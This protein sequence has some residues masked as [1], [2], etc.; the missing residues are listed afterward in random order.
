[1]SARVLVSVSPFGDPF[2]FDAATH[3]SVLDAR[4]VFD[5][6][7]DFDALVDSDARFVSDVLAD[8]DA[9]FVLDVFFVSDVLGVSGVLFVLGV[10]VASVAVWPAGVVVVSVLC[11]AVHAPSLDSIDCLNPFLGGCFDYVVAPVFVVG[12]T[13]VALPYQGACLWLL[14]RDG[15]VR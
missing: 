4:F 7:A 10:S 2:G 9:R 1:M 12:R 6:L 8:F 5:V 3:W 13:V 11:A 15:T 14:A